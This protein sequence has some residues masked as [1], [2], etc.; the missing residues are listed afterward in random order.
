M[1]RYFKMLLSL[2]FALVVAF[3]IFGITGG[4][5]FAA[6]QEEEGEEMTEEEYEAYM[7]EY[8]AWETADKEPDILKSGAMLIELIRKNPGS[9]MA[10]YAEG[11]YMRLLNKCVEEKKY[12][13]LESLAEQWNVFKPGNEN[14]VRMIAAAAKELKHTEKYIQ[15]LEEMY[16]RTPQLDY[17]KEIASLYKDEI[18][19]DAKYVEWTEIIMKESGEASDF[20]RHYELFQHYSTKKDTA[21][22]MDYAQSTLKAIDQTKNPPADVAKILPTIRQELNHYIGTRYYS[23]KK[24]DNAITYFLKALKDKKYSEGYYLIGNCLWEQKKILN[25]RMAF[26]K[27]QLFGESAQASKEDKAYAPRAKERMEQLHRALHNDTL[28]G[29]N[30]RYKQAQEMSDEDLI[31]PMD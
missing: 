26:A 18:K 3:F 9:K 30:N 8:T 14:I 17:A 25:A 21:K 20:V 28:T 31:K 27:A 24:Y 13:E 16:K 10:P 2:L 11:S 7:A 1:N 23:D 15:I 4:P 22:M 12:Q 19:N 29:I 5:A 6:V